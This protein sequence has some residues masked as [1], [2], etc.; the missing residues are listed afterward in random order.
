MHTI[1]NCFR[2]RYNKCRENSI[3]RRDE[4]LYPLL[5]YYPLE[6][7]KLNLVFFFLV[8]IKKKYFYKFKK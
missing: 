5:Y 3:I 1:L 6:Q 8:E 2:R 7:N 4:I